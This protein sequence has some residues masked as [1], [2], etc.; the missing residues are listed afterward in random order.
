METKRKTRKA[1]TTSGN[2]LIV[3]LEKNAVEKLAGVSDSADVSETFKEQYPLL[4]PF[5][6]AAIIEN[7]RNEIKYSI[8]EPTLQT[9]IKRHLPS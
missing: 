3:D 7:E 6:Y 9:R 4:I 5:S 2:G 8:L 1:E